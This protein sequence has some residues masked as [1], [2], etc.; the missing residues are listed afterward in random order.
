MKQESYTIVGPENIHDFLEYVKKE[1]KL[2]AKETPNLSKE[3]FAAKC[4]LQ[5]PF[6]IDLNTVTNIYYPKYKGYCLALNKKVK[7][8]M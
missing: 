1:I 7:N 3:E 2:L 5:L 6:K 8:E 4:R